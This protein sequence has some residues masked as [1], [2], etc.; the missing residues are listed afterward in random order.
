MSNKVPYSPLTFKRYNQEFRHIKSLIGKID[1]SRAGEMMQLLTL[2]HT[3]K[4]PHTDYNTVK[5]TEE[6]NASNY[7][8][9]I[10]FQL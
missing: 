3:D 1:P 9:D 2:P 4:Q 10:K 7:R 6:R 8:A 5:C